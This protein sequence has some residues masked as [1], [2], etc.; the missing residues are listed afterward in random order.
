VS[1]GVTLGAAF[2][3]AARTLAAA[4]VTSAQLDA[5]LLLGR[6]LGVGPVEIVAEPER[7]VDPAAGR[8]LAGLVARR[9]ARE[10]MSHILGVREFWGLEFT[11]TRDTLDP[12][13]DSE[14]VVEE[15]LAGIG[16][17]G[18]PLRVLDFGTG[19]GCLLL[20]LL[21]EL[22]AARGIGVDRSVAALAVARAN[23]VRLGLGDRAAFV[24]GSWG[25]SLAGRFDLIVANPPYVRS[26][27]I[28]ALAPEVARFE[29]RLALDG[30][31]DGLRCY[32]D[33]APAIAR[34][35]EPNGVA[36]LEVGDDQADDVVGIMAGAGLGEAAIERDLA[37]RPRC[38]V[39]T[40]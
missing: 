13:P 32:R 15:A 28:T 9:A 22:P 19:T 30:G 24:A 10:P 17:R 14:T 7:P 31:A 5:R 27:A 38:V 39:L 1:G 29:P 4:G 6:V 35:L 21:A 2:H 8:A 11:V 16:G 18:R 12:R 20:A 25:D 26:A 23:A 3:A 37:H 34:L 36:A 40:R 33:L